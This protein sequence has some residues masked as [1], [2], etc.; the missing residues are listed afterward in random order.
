MEQPSSIN[1]LAQLQHSCT[2]QRAQPASAESKDRS[3]YK[4]LIFSCLT[5]TVVDDRQD[6]VFS[7]VL[8][9]Y[10]TLTG[11]SLTKH[12]TACDLNWC[13]E[14]YC[15]PRQ[16]FLHL[17]LLTPIVSCCSQHNIHGITDRSQVILFLLQSIFSKEIQRQPCKRGP[18]KHPKSKAMLP[19]TLDLC[20]LIPSSKKNKLQQS[21]ASVIFRASCLR[22]LEQ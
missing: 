18:E 3:G 7:P 8:M 19:L 21:H 5:E 15:A 17:A 20:Y 16:Q 9:S 4:Y 1:T 2:E 13:T 6:Q 11:T 14:R 12:Q 22:L 10:K